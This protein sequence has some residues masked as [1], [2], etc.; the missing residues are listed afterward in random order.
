MEHS[1]HTPVNEAEID[2]EGFADRLKDAAEHIKALF[3]KRH[4]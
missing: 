4:K 2:K 1:P 3:N